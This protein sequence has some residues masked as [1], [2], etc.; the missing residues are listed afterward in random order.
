MA[1]EHHG[2][3]EMQFQQQYQNAK[4][5]IIPF[6]NPEFVV[7][8]GKQVMDIGCGEGGVLKAFVEAGC[9]C[10]GVDLSPDRITNAIE[11]QKESVQAG[12]L[13]FIAQN[14]Y[15]FPVTE[16]GQT[17]LIIFKDS[18]EHIP[19]QQKII[20]HCKK[21]LKPDGKIFL[22]FPPWAMPF[23]GHQQICQ[24]K[25]FS[26]LPWFHLLPAPVYHKI[27]DM[28]GEEKDIIDE[29][30]D[31]KRL[32][33]YTK[34]FENKV[35]QAGF[36]IVKRKLFLINPIYAYKFNMQPKEQ[37]NFISKIPFVRDFITTTAYY[38]LTP[39]K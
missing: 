21:F 36:D 14:I 8:E 9:S 10:L 12:K 23:G 24:S 33:L 29:L 30:M 4:D 1:L 26:K 15:D 7:G 35:H 39:Q 6:L 22:G 16:H 20:A 38:L 37:F 32:G 19:D 3:A 28:A 31:I 5:H 27:L 34:S 18:I 13:K 2:N 25:F 11:I 17:D